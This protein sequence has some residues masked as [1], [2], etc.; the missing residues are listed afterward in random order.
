MF[1]P[2]ERLS[3]FFRWEIFEAYDCDYLS[4]TTATNCDCDYF[5]PWLL[6]FVIRTTWYYD[7]LWL[8]LR[9]LVLRLRL[10]LLLLLL[11]FYYHYF[12]RTKSREFM[13]I[14]VMHP[15]LLSW[16]FIRE[17]LTKYKDS[18]YVHPG[19]EWTFWG[20][21]KGDIEINQTKL[22]TSRL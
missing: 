9:P 1:T 6:A 7:F 12:Y 4:L 2:K 17:C 15:R 11:L 20:N 13:C 3:S 21:V 16:K 8:Q 5:Q 22:L 10:W 19:A 14:Q 18:F